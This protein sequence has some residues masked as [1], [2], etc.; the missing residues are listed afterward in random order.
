MNTAPFTNR[1]RPINMV[2]SLSIVVLTTWLIVLFATAPGP[3]PGYGIT[4][5]ELKLLRYSQAN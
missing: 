4:K 3:S 1:H 2:L 5:Q